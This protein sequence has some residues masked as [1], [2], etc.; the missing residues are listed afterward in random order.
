MAE[1]VTVSIDLRMTAEDK[2]TLEAMAKQCGTSI[3]GLLTDFSC[4]LAKSIFSNDAEGQ[5]LARAWFDDL[6][7]RRP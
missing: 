5:R 6:K 4:D 1:M 2:A 7:E 3:W